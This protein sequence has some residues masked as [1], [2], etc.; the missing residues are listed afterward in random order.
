MLLLGCRRFL[1][2]CFSLGDW[3]V[4]DFDRWLQLKPCAEAAERP[5]QRVQRAKSWEERSVSEPT[6]PT[7]CVILVCIKQDTWTRWNLHFPN[8]SCEKNYFIHRKAHASPLAHIYLQW[9]EQFQGWLS[10]FAFAF[11][12]STV[13]FVLHKPP[14]EQLLQTCLQAQSF[15]IYRKHAHP[16]YI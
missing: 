12:F 7:S 16:V 2:V 15:E 3:T 6:E 14:E 13:F 5:W 4:R 10:F 11:A 9:I 8:P 1:L